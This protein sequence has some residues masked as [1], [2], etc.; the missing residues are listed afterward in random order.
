MPVKSK[1]QLRFMQM[2]AHNPE[3]MK[4]KPK[5]LTPEKAQE[6]IDK[7]PKERFSRLKEYVGKKK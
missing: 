6:F 4:N 7:T 1:A 3:K 2:A 5:S